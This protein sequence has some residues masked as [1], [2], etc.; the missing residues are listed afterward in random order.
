MATTTTQ[1]DEVVEVLKKEQL[2]SRHS[3]Y[4]NYIDNSVGVSIVRRNN[5]L[6]KIHVY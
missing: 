4:T 1:Y 2:K 5:K 3:T 6:I